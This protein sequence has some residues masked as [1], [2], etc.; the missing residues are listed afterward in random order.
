MQANP[1]ALDALEVLALGGRDVLLG[2]A[3]VAEDVAV[4]APE[5]IIALVVYRQDLAA[6]KLGLW[7]E[8]KG[9]W[10][11]FTLTTTLPGR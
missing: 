5:E 1:D 2:R 3:L 10:R 4:A 7:W 11:I 6:D 9:G 8:T